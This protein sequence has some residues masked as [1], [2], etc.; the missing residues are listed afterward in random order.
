MFQKTTISAAIL[1]AI[2][3]LATTAA[4]AQ[5]A[6]ASDVQ[7]V[8]ITGSS[9]KRIA[10]EGALPIQTVTAEDIKKS[11]F[12]TT[13]E[14]VQNLSA[15]QGFTT[16]SQSVNGGGGG[17]T[18]ASLHA[19]GSKYTLVLLNGRRLAP[20]NTGSEVNLNSIPLGAIERVEVLTDGASALYGADAIAGV[21]NFITRKDATDGAVTVSGYVPQ[22]AGGRSATA[23][24]TKGFGDL[25]KDHFNVL[26]TATFDK[27]QQLN[28]SQRSFSKSGVLNFNDQYGAEQVEID[29]SNNVP[30]NATVELNIP[31]GNNDGKNKIIKFNPYKVANGSCIPGD[32]T[33]GNYCRYDY[34]STVQTIPKEERATLFGSGRYQFD[35][36]NSV[37][38]ELAFANFHT[39]A[40]YAAVAQPF[41]ISDAL[42]TKDI[43]P[44]LPKLG[45]APGVE[46]QAGD[47]T[48]MNV[49][50]VDAGRRTDRYE[51]N[52]VHAVLGTDFSLGKFD[53]TVTYTHSQSHF[54]DK[55][56]GGY[57][58]TN[59][60]DA[61]LASGAF[62][63]LTSPPGS[64]VSV[65][66]PAVLHSTLDASRSSID[67]LH[68]NTSTT[69]A[70][71]PGGDLGAAAGFDITHQKYSDS[72]SA[73]SQGT[74]VL[75]PNFTDSVFGGSSGLPPFDSSRNNY[76]VYGELAAPVTKALELD[77]A[78]RFDS[79]AKVK[80]K[81]T[82]DTT[83][84][85][86]LGSETQGKSSSAT[87]FKLSAAFR[88]TK[89]WLL[90]ASL[91]S[92]FK[93]PTIADISN[94]QE[95]NGN[96]GMHTCPTGLSA[97]KANFCQSGPYEYNIDK[98]GNPATN[99]IGLK[100]ERSTQW[101][102]GSRFEPSPTISVGLDLWSVNIR[103]QINKITE[104][105]AF[106]NG[107]VYD[108]LF[109]VLKD[110]ISGQ[111]TL[112]F[113]QQSVNTGKAQYQGLDLDAESHVT[114]PFGKLTTT[115]HVTYMTKA[116]YQTPGQSGYNN[117]VNKVGLDGQ[118]TFRWQADV[119]FSLQTGGF[120]NTLV[121]RAKPGY[122]DDY[123]DY[124]YNSPT[125]YDSDGTCG[126]NNG[127]RRVSS[128]TTFDWQTRYD[129]D[130]SF[131]LTG[132]IR[133]LFDRNP[134]FTI[135]DQAN[136]SNA[137]GFDGRYTDPLGRTFYASGTY[138]F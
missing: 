77:G 40:A 13:T 91:G 7:R 51:T 82:F 34:A 123:T 16:S 18:T 9:I 63:P 37:F 85:A 105:T 118:V 52:A 19:M 109:A 61:L 107:A 35:D 115:G 132:G 12:T 30:A 92:G 124:C 6:P 59:A 74:N 4:Q 58:S 53:S 48:T 28:A 106:S 111:Q 79:F 94:P 125:G 38:T 2:N 25:Y 57:S 65:L 66:A 3:A 102:I 71:L 114:T 80:N 99:S 41:A 10:S 133:N 137:R 20:F 44:L 22:K 138:K 21:V 78:V 134:P 135:N 76:G 83:T 54:F 68:G 5:E 117:S 120:T 42:L 62:D 96:T 67:T 23:S 104:D 26:L 108:Y 113:L 45:Y 43:D 32:T 122:K 126:P 116:N 97:A 89:E 84:G 49:R 64:A 90:R 29:S 95:A 8:E 31:S 130:K 131:S 15:M 87:T 119:A 127:N 93:V 47:H 11:G 100:P 24:I 98:L 60:I 112:T 88:P 110:P 55:A 50:L 128:Y 33:V 129:F 70:S 69:L 136:T 75:Q 56:E 17:V 27:Q 46:G 101:T 121:V 39:D 36:R 1:L 103:D 73:I 72:P 86:F 81:E 14:L